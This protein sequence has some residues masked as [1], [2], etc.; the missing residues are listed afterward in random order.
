MIFW[1]PAGKF[2]VELAVPANAVASG[3]TAISRSFCAYWLRAGSASQYKPYPVRTTVLGLIA[4]ATPIRGPQLSLIGG[5]AK[6][7][8]PASTTLF[9]NNGSFTTASWM[10]GLALTTLHK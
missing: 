9:L 10:Q 3:H 2:A 4:Q 8:L 6:N 1:P 7:F 5:G